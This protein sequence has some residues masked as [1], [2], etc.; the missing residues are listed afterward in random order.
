MHRIFDNKGVVGSEFFNLKRDNFE[1]S[2][3]LLFGLYGLTP[4]TYGKIPFLKDAPDILVYSPIGHLFV[5]ECTTTDIGRSGKLLKLSQRTREIKSAISQAG[6]GIIHV[7]PMMVTQL[8]REET[9]ACWEE[10]AN[11]GISLVCR[12]DIQNLINSVERPSS[13]Q[14]LFDAAMELIPQNP[15]EQELQFQ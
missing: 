12:E 14:V 7:L 4:I 1:D 11:F 13:P 15:R 6:T 5:V 2:I 8:M 10:A 3:S 9:K